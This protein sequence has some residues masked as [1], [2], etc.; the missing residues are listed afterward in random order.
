[1]GKRTDKMNIWKR[2]KI[3]FVKPEGKASEPFDRMWW[4]IGLIILIIVSLIRRKFF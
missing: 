3:K 2:S 1:M 4:I